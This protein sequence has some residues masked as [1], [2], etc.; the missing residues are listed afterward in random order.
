MK[1]IKTILFIGLLATASVFGQL[2]TLVQ[3][4]LSAAITNNQ[5]SFAVA[6]ATGIVAPTNTAAGSD[7]WVQDVG[8]TMGELM[9]VQSIS[10]TTLTVRRTSSRATAHATGAMVLVATA[11]NWFQ[12]K[13]PRG[14]CTTASTYVTPWLNTTNGLQWLC[15]A[16]T[17][18]WVPGWGN[19]SAIPQVSAATAVASVG[20]TTAVDGPLIHVS[21][22]N[23]VTAW[24]PTVGWYGQPFCVYPDA[25]YTTTNGGTTVASTRVI[26][27]GAAAS[28]AVIGKIQCYTYDVTNAK[29]GLSY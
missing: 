1:N 22:T 9:T 10:S 25:A 4:S 6:S 3:T 24:Q 26:A 17:L 11:P 2:N 15:S 14:A 7:I 23:A 29:F 16:K 18:A 12:Q 19:T 8:Q 5:T 21:G 13:D 28:T 27:M 20:G